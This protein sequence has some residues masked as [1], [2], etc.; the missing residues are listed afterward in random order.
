VHLTLEKRVEE[1]SLFN[2]DNG[3]WAKHV[4][5]EGDREK[6]PKN[7]HCNRENFPGTDWE[8]GI[9]P[10][11]QTGSSSSSHPRTS[12]LSKKK[13][14]RGNNPQSNKI[15]GTGNNRVL[16]K[17]FLIKVE[18]RRFTIGQSFI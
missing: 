5:F 2:R 1:T 15:R 6:K 7:V 10:R 11:L 16:S 17:E 12:Y 4:R 3:I 9:F 13:R 18:G 14:K 8:A